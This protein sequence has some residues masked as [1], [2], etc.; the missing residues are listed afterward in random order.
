M[1]YRSLIALILGTLVTASAFPQDVRADTDVDTPVLVVRAS[2]AFGGCLPLMFE[3]GPSP[4]D[5]GGFSGLL[6]ASYGSLQNLAL[7]IEIG[8]L[9]VYNGN[10][11]STGTDTYDLTLAFL[12]VSA[13]LFVNG[14]GGY[15][16][17]GLG[18]AFNVSSVRRLAGSG[19]LSAEGFFF[20]RAEGGFNIVT[21]GPVQL[22]IGV[23]MYLPFNY[24]VSPPPE[25]FATQL[26][27]IC[28]T[29]GVKVGL[30]VMLV[31]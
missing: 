4:V 11:R 22:S 3:N 15:G 1:A 5:A 6:Q 7:G 31:L 13:G 12:P 20:L 18:Y 30:S 28:F 9:S 26:P 21:L 8:Y 17:M 24:P 25:E 16:S 10:Y 2:G 29:A 27:M 23:F 19:A 14:V